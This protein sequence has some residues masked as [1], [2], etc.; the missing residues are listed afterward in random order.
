MVD[1]PLL[2]VVHPSVPAA[3]VA[4][5]VAL[6]KARPGRLA[7]GSGGSFGG[8]GGSLRQPVRQL[9]AVSG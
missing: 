8:S 6:A 4:Q 2:V 5:L 9:T 7:Y 3:N 1:A